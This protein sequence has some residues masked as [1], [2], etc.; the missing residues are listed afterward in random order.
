MTLVLYVY[1]IDNGINNTINLRDTLMWIILLSF[2]FFM[3]RVLMVELIRS[4]VLELVVTKEELHRCNQITQ[5]TLSGCVSSLVYATLFPT[6]M[7]LWYIVEIGFIQAA[8]LYIAMGITAASMLS[9]LNVYNKARKMLQNKI[10][11]VE[12]GKYE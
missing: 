12:S 6:Y 4:L 9:E 7:I 5:P 8:M 2:V 3:K 10:A 1:I 11:E